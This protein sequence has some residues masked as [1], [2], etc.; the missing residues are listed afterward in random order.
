M[1]ASETVDFE[2]EF[3]ELV[4][5]LRELPSEAPPAV[6]ERV[7]ALGEPAPRRV[8]FPQL[9]WR[10]ATLV[11]V[12]ACAVALVAA[13]AIHGLVSS[14]GNTNNPVAAEVVRQNP[15]DHKAA[16]KGSGGATMSAGTQT[17]QVFGALVAPD[18]RAPAIPTPNPV[19]HQDYEADL[20]LR[21]K[22]LDTLGQKTAQAMRVTQ[23]LGGYVA[24]LS[25]ST[26]AGQ[27]GEADLVLRVPVAH[28]TD[29]M[30]RLSALGTVL[31]QHVS[32]VDLENA[33]QQQRQRIR[34]L[35]LQIVRIT[36][37][38]QQPGL[39][40]DERL[41]LQFQL[42]D[43]RRNLSNATGQNKA[44]LREAAVSRISLSLTTQ[45]PIAPAKKHHK[46]FFGRATSS[47]FD[48]L[49]GA[50]AIAVAG[51]IILS[52]LLVLGGLIFWG[53]RSYRRREAQRLL[54]TT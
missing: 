52:P 8:F 36:A 2:R 54:G 34:A 32:I 49:A 15:N 14:S 9:T 25:Q 1:P 16:G 26:T 31:E 38:L 53:V 10:R 23:Q 7:R 43:A 24:S 44:T 33:V 51:L 18:V 29:A 19:R 42:D 21:V 45:S 3:D 48:F 47:A 12:P 13:A 40:A 28:V 46:G 4:R 39:S 22:D 50:G 37:A 30:V 11:L 5:E 6:R 35:R 41:R 20:R 17:T 27:P